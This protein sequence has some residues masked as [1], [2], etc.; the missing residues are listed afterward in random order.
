MTPSSSLTVHRG[1][2]L[3]CLNWE[4]IFAMKHMVIEIRL[5]VSFKK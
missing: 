3:A 2:K 1:Y 4:C 5:N